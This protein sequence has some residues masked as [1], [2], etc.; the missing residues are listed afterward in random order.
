MHVLARLAS[1]AIAIAVAAC[2]PADSGKGGDDGGGDGD[3][4]GGAD[5]PCANLE[6]KQVDC[7]GGATTSLSGTVFAPNGTLPLYN[8]IVYV[9]NGTVEGF[10][11]EVGCDRCGAQL[12][13]DPLVQTTTDTAGAFSL[14][15]VPVG[16]DIPLV[17]QIGR[18]RRQVSIPSVPEC[19]DTP[20][21]PADTR[22]PKNRS[23]GDIPRIALTTGEADALECLLRKIGLDDTQ[24]S[25]EFGIKGS[26]QRVHFYA[27]FDGTP[28]FNAALGGQSFTPAPTFW[29]DLDNLMQYDIVI[30]SCEGREDAEQD[31]KSLAARDALE[32]Y[33]RAGGRVFMSHWHHYWLEFGPAPWPGL[34]SYRHA[35]D[36]GTLTA[37]IDQTFQKGKDLAAWLANVVPGS[38]PGRIRLNETRKEVGGITASGTNKGVERWISHPSQAPD[39]V[40]YLAMN[41]PVDVPQE[42]RCGRMVLSDIHVSQDSDSDPSSAFPNDCSDGELTAQEKVLAFMLFDISACIEPPEEVE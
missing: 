31:N 34:L 40:Q 20:V 38:T 10:P 14:T 16:D 7:A 29:N 4:G 15:D 35:G 6:C 8:A 19:V 33:T 27:A 26:D 18:W 41:T 32:A 25:K 11:D 30:H 42:E 3:G 1:T 23:E 39:S 9:P 22:L 37:K 2:G 13:G 28:R 24:A 17:I 12:S 36:T 5:R 21:D